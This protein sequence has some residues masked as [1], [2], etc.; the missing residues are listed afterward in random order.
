MA[1]RVPNK[2]VW[3]FWLAQDG[4][5]YHIF[6]LQA[7]RSLQDEGLRHWNVSVGHAVSQNLRDWDI[8]PDA[9][10]PSSTE[11]WDDYTTWTG[12]II[13]HN[14][15]WYLF[16]TGGCRAE[17]GKIQ[18]VGLATSIDLIH[19]DKHPDNP[20][21]EASPHFYE[22][23]DLNLWFDQ[24]WRDPW[25]FQHP[26]T[27]E[28]HAYITARCNYGPADGRGVIAHARS[29]D[30]LNWEVLPPVTA[31]GDFGQLEVPQ[32][33]L[34]QNRYYMLFCTA[35]STHAA[36][37]QRKTGVEPVRGTHYLVADNLLGPFRFSTR[38]FLVGDP[39]GSFYNG[40]LV[41]GPD[42]TWYFMAS[43]QFTPGGD[44][45]GALS[46]PMPVTIEDDG[47][48]SVNWQEFL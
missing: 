15:L 17:N 21:L 36:D 24:A 42:D 8:L 47:N 38:E 18:R 4:P 9:L 48:L 40:K 27:G 6:Y 5:D 16:Y 25:L 20:L 32:L 45:I 46:D 12:S 23:L 30:L 34:I 41:Q 11:T 14:S 35:A 13:K 44:F 43:R 26:Q 2:W 10:H 28:F 1:L 29:T 3:D 22:Q 37:Y 33:V 31:P 19:W 39:I 7:P